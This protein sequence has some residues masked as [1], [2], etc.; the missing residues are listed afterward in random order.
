MNSR[1]S[2]LGYPE[3]L[4]TPAR[5]IIVIAW[6]SQKSKWSAQPERD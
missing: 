4:F 1:E 3:L 5:R 6:S 2:F